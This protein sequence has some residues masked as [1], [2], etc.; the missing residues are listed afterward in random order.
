VTSPV[1]SVALG[2]SAWDHPR[3]T[4]TVFADP[5]HAY[6]SGSTQ[7][8]DFP[9]TTGAPTPHGSTGSTT[10]ICN[11][12][13]LEIGDVFVAKFDQNVVLEWSR[14]LGGTGDDTAWGNV[15]LDPDGDVFIGGCTRSPTL[16]DP[17]TAGGFDFGAS[18]YGALSGAADGFVAK[19]AGATG[20]ALA[21]RFHGGSGTD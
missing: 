15:R 17:T 12:A 14:C 1:L 16:I 2:G 19:F 5:P 8:S 7:S 10:S 13:G 21:L 11:T 18:I 20:K 6:F 9:V 3:G 4:I